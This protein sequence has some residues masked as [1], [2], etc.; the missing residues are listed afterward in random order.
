MI[1]WT[2]LLSFIVAVFAVVPAVQPAACPLAPAPRL[3]PGMAA[4]VAPELWGLNLRALPAVS[5]G[6]RAQIGAGQRMTVL[7][8]P[9]CNGRYQWVQVE[10]LNGVRG[11]LAEGSWDGAYVVPARADGQPRALVDPLDWSCPAW[12]PGRHCPLP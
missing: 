12:L 3:H 11:W 1:G 5:T 9:V 8:G 4:V 6:V 10:L 7:A 2:V